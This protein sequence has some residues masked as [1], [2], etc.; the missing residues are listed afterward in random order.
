MSINAQDLPDLIAAAVRKAVA[1]R[2]FTDE[3]LAK[4]VHSP[5]TIGLMATP[6]ATQHVSLEGERVPFP[7]RTLGFQVQSLDDLRHLDKVE[8]VNTLANEK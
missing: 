5:I 3:E 6:S 7:F 8:A 1:E 4:L 2:H